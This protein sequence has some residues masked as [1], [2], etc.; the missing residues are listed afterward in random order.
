MKPEQNETE[1]ELLPC[2]S[3]LLHENNH[4]WFLCFG[5]AKKSIWIEESVKCGAI[6]LFIIIIDACRGSSRGKM[7]F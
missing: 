3:T 4:C 6:F 5:F 7:T 2:Q 1:I